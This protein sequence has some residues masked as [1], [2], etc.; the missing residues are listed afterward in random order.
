MTELLSGLEARARHLSKIK[1]SKKIPVLK[2][3]K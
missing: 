3:G 1:V 2:K